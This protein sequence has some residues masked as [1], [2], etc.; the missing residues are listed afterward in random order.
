MDKA[1]AIVRLFTRVVWACPFGPGSPLQ[2]RCSQS[3]CSGLSATVPHAKCYHQ[4]SN[5]LWNAVLIRCGHGTHFRALT[6]T[7]EVGRL[8]PVYSDVRPTL[9]GWLRH[10]FVLR[11]S[12]SARGQIRQRSVKI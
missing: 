2:V 6:A 9:Q 4:P 3:L 10:W 11:R 1:P 12:P 7:D 5:V 8:K